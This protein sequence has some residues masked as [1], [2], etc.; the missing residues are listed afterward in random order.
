MLK[1]LSTFALSTIM[2]LGVI[3]SVSLV[4]AGPALA[5]KIIGNG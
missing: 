3:V 4:S 5:G 1:R 2:A